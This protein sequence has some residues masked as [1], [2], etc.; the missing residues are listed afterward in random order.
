MGRAP[1]AAVTHWGRGVGRSGVSLPEHGVTGFWGTGEGSWTVIQRGLVQGRRGQYNGAGVAPNQT[2]SRTTL[3]G[4]WAVVPAVLPQTIWQQG[5]WRAAGGGAG[6]ARAWGQWGGTGGTRH[7]WPRN[8]G[9]VVLFHVVQTLD[10]NCWGSCRKRGGWEQ[11]KKGWGKTRVKD[12]QTL[13]V[14][15]QNCIFLVRPAQTITA[16]T[17][18]MSVKQAQILEAIVQL[19]FLSFWWYFSNKFYCWFSDTTS[20]QSS[21]PSTEILT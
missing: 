8:W 13:D 14:V 19:P 11:E 12:N 20:F 7:W 15:A 1:G 2:L 4:P 17:V 16:W 9:V 10:G 21:L 5:A 18:A 6:A 3:G